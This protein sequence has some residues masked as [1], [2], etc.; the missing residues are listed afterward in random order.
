MSEQPQATVTWAG[1]TEGEREALK[2]VAN[3]KTPSVYSGTEI[4]A[5]GLFILD[6]DAKTCELTDLGKQVL[7]QAT[8]A[9]KKHPVFNRVFCVCGTCANL[10]R[11][12]V[13]HRQ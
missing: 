8:V 5:K 10:L 1:L 2:D 13:L 9:N 12:R 6:V 4:Y 3:G 11:R 7:A